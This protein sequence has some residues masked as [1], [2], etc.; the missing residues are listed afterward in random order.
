VE[1]SMVTAPLDLQQ[2]LFDMQIAGY[3]P[4]IAHPE[5]Y[6]YLNR[7]KEFFDELKDAGCFFQLN[8][9]SLT[10]YYGKSVQDLAEWLA[11]RQYYNFA[12]TDMHTVKHV[13]GLKRLSASSAFRKLKESGN[14]KNHVL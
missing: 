10:G 14:L 7:K 8:L 3:Q 12:G 6:I 13:E 5:R 11:A 1:F 2:V 9:L 4:V